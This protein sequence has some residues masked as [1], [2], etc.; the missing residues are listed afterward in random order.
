[1]PQIDPTALSFEASILDA[2]KL[3]ARLCA[4]QPWIALRAVRLLSRQSRASKVRR[5]HWARGVHVPPFCIHSVT[6]RCNLQCA[7]CYAHALHKHEDRE[8]MDDACTARFFR[9]ASDLGVSVILL[10]GGEP[11]LR[12]RLLHLTEAAPKILFL[13]FSNGSRLDTSAIAHLKRQPHVLPVLSLEGPHSFTDA[14]RGPGTHE[15]VLALMDRLK[16]ARIFFGS[17]TTLTRENLDAATGEDHVASLRQHGCRLFFYINYVPAEP[18]TESMQLL[19]E[20]VQ[21]LTQRLEQYRRTLGSLFIAFPQDEIALGGCLAAGRGFV[22]INAYGD[23]EPCPFSP[24]SDR[25]LQQGSLLEALASPFL[26]RIR[27]ADVTLDETNGQCALW[28]QKAW[29]HQLWTDVS[30][31]SS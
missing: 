10:A 24:Y 23:I 14:R 30:H 20:Q 6:S 9:E 22:H 5:R 19:P 16:K 12:D 15:A 8:E 26:R 28:Q 1:L 7:G 17:A 18:G 29:V 3:G 25:S 21:M 27:A 2:L 31:P 13:L 11:L 4:R